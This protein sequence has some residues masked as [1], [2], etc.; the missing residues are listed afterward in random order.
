M[1]LYILDTD[2]LSLYGRNH[3]TLISR[4]IVTQIPLTTTVINVEEQLKGRLAQVASAKDAVTQSNAYQRLV[5]TVMLLSEFNVLHYDTK[6]RNIYQSL[7]LQRIRV[8][9]QDLKIA[10]ITLAYNGILL[11][12]NLQDFEKVP[13]LNIQNWIN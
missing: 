11:T 8:G 9:T 4:L 13:E 6:S 2:H 1:T 10:S 12:R 3:P 5:E 7:K